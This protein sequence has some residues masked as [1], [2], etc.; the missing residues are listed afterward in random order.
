MGGCDKCMIPEEAVGAF[1]N[2]IL[3]TDAIVMERPS[4]W[5]RIKN[6]FKW[7]ESAPFYLSSSP[8]NNFMFVTQIDPFLQDTVLKYLAV[9]TTTLTNRWE[10]PEGKLWTNLSSGMHR[11]R[12]ATSHN[13]VRVYPDGITGDSYYPVHNQSKMHISSNTKWQIKEG[14]VVEV[15]TESSL[16]DDIEVWS[17][18]LEEDLF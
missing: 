9:N 15:M 8:E 13:W 10:V 12:N 1:I 2:R 5:P 16:T 6:R 17:S 3:G 14:G 11:D 4:L 7:R 18:V